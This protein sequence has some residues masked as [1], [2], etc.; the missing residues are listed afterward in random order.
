MFTI[1]DEQRFNGNTLLRNN[2]LQS[3]LSPRGQS[4]PGSWCGRGGRGGGSGQRRSIFLSSD[5]LC[6]RQG[7]DG[8]GG[9]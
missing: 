8:G 5:L 4:W 9:E 2:V 1:T 6:L 3:Y 7:C